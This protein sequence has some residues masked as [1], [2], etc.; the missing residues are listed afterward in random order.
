MAPAKLGLI[1]SIYFAGMATAAFILPRLSDIY[2]RKI[3]YVVSMTGIFVTYF[4][5]LLSKNLNLTIT[6]MFF[7]GF[8]SL[9]RSTVGYLYMQELTPIK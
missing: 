2:G 5:I 7:F 3:I 9:G 1:G 6:I 4:L 8:F